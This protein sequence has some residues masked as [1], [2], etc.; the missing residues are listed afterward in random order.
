MNL[1]LDT[2]AL[3]WPLDGAPALSS[4][5]H[6]AMAD[7]SWRSRPTIGKCFRRSPQAD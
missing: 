3:L 1:L 7:G 2:H 4:T 6:A 5:A